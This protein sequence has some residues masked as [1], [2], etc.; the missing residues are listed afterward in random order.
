MKKIILICIIIHIIY[1][2]YYYSLLYYYKSLPITISTE[3]IPSK[4][5][6]GKNWI[7]IEW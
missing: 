3:W 5:F 1:F 7:G 4:F 2:Y 6:V